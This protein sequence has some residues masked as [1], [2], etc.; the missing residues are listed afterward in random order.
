MRKEAKCRERE[1][2][3]L[4]LWIPTFSLP[5]DHSEWVPPDPISNSEVKPF[6]ADDSVDFSCESRSLPGFLF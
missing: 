4:A 5:G 6:S 3:I 2:K 1:T